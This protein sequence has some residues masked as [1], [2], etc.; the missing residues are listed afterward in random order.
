MKAWKVKEGERKMM[1]VKRK[2][3]REIGRK[4]K[5]EQEKEV[6]N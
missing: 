2:K 6:E 5:R 1:G 4:D 3:D